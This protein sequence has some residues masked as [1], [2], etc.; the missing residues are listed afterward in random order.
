MLMVALFVTAPWEPDFNPG[1]P[2]A[3]RLLTQPETGTLAFGID[4]PQVAFGTYAA[5]LI[6]WTDPDDSNAATRDRPLS[7]YGT[8]LD[9]LD[10]AGAITLDRENPDA[11][12]LVLPP[13]EL[14]GSA[15]DMRSH[16]PPVQ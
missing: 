8:T 15:G 14:F 13:F 5:L 1:P 2:A 10:Q 16:Y 7:V 4:K 11:T 3:F 12:G 9:A 6:V